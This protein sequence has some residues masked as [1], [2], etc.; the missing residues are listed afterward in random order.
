M[1]ERKK[2]EVTIESYFMG[3]DGMMA[4]V[5]AVHGYP[6]NSYDVSA[7]GDTYGEWHC[8]GYRIRTDLIFL[9]SEHAVEEA[10]EM[11]HQDWL[12]EQ[13]T[14]ESVRP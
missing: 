13:A 12:D 14:R 11:E 1:Y 5:K 3:G 2:V 7:Q 9:E 6:F 4:N 8:N 10:Y